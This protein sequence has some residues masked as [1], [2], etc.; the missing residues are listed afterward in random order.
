MK[1]FLSLLFCVSTCSYVQADTVHI[2][3]KVNFNPGFSTIENSKLQSLDRLINLLEKENLN[4][5]FFVAG[6]SDSLGSEAINNE[7]SE[8]RAEFIKNALINRGVEENSIISKGF[9]ERAPIAD[10][11][12]R[13][14]RNKNR[15]VVV[16]LGLTNIEEQKVAD[17]RSSIARQDGYFEVLNGEHELVQGFI[18]ENQDKLEENVNQKAED[19]Q[20]LERPEAVSASEQPSG[21]S[22][23]GAHRYQLGLGTYQ[24]ILNIRSLNTESAGAEA[25]WVSKQNLNIGLAYQYQIAP[26]WW[27]GLRANYHIQD[28]EPIKSST[29]IWDEENPSMIRASLI[30][31]YEISNRWGLGLDLDYN[32]EAFVY[33]SS[34]SVTLRKAFVAGASLR[35]LYKF[36]DSDRISARLNLK[37][38]Y[39]VSGSDEILDPEGKIGGV[40]GVDA[41]LKNILGSHELNFNLYFATRNFE[42]LANDQKEKLVGFMVSVRN[43]KWL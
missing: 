31:D 28:Y 42:N 41:S 7:L 25:E 14:G 43:N 24:N 2:G 1:F 30:T 34:S 4:A 23:I 29:F 33:E 16:S 6:H 21:L 11:K 19:V 32:E 9:G 38:S 13:E 5:K 12:T 15:R 37:V 17:F 8:A 35:G 3:L 27:L 36:Y 10:N 39:P 20:P 26:A 18:A 40:F 22:F